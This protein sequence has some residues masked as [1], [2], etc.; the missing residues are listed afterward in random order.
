MYGCKKV[1]IYIH[2]RILNLL[3]TYQMENSQGEPLRAFNSHKIKNLYYGIIIIEQ[4]IVPFDTV[5]Q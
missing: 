2:G 4:C 1:D 5:T 3:T